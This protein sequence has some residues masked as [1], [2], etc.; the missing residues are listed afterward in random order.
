LG[1]GT[2]LLSAASCAAPAAVG[3]EGA[4]AIA[5]PGGVVLVSI[6]SQPKG[7]SRAQLLAWVEGCART[8][9]SFYGAFPISRVQLTIRPGGSGKIGGG[10]TEGWSGRATIVISVGDGT[11]EADL[12]ADSEL[13]HEMVHQAFPSMPRG[14]AWIEEGIAVYVEPIARARAGRASTDNIW[15]W[16]TKGLPQGLA[17]VERR[18]LDESRSWGATYWGGALFCLLADVEI[19]ER[20]GNRKSLDDALRGIVHAGGNVTVNWD[21]DRAFAEGDKATGVPVLTELHAKMGSKPVDTDLAALWK[22]LG[23]SVEKSGIVYDDTAPLAAI[24]RGIATGK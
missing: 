13:T 19:R 18:G 22:R 20:T 24:R 17:G 14:K 5:V 3:G 11:T 23:I 10:R 9:A 6:P 7:V 2:L 15:R 12:A 4:A 16:M 8:V 1:L 21:L